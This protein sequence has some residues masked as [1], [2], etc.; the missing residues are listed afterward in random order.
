MSFKHYLLASV[1]AFLPISEL[2]AQTTTPLAGDASNA[3]VTATGGTTART[4]ADQAADIVNAKNYGVKG[5]LQTLSSNF[6]ISASSTALSASSGV[7]SASMVGKSIVLGGAGAAGAALITTIASYTD[8]THVTLTAA[9]STALS[10]ASLTVAVGTDDA[11]ALNAAFAAAVAKTQ[12]YSTSTNI[13]AVFVV[14]QGSYLTLESLNWT[15][16]K[17]NGLTVQM[18]SALIY[19]ATN[20]K[21]IIDALGTRWF[22]W[23]GGILR[24]DPYAPPNVGL[25]IGRINTTSQDSS[26]N[27]HITDLAI[28]GYFSLAGFYDM[29]VEQSLFTRLHVFNS[30]QGAYSAIFDGI[31]HFG[32]T[33]QFVTVSQPADTPQSFLGNQFDDCI[34]YGNN[35]SGGAIWLAGTMGMLFHTGYVV[36]TYAGGGAL[37]GATLYNI[38]SSINS[39]L[40]ADIHFEGSITSDWFI[41]GTNTT[42]VFNGFQYF[43][44]HSM[45]SQYVIAWDT[46]ITFVTLTNS[47]YEVSL[48]P[49]GTVIFQDPTKMTVSGRWWTASTSSWPSSPQSFQGV[50]QLGAGYRLGQLSAGSGTTVTGQGA[51]AAGQ[52]NLASGLA[53]TA[54]GN[55]NQTAGAYSFAAGSAVSDAADSAF[56]YGSGAFSSTDAQHRMAVMRANMTTANTTYQLTTNGSQTITGHSS[57]GYGSLGAGS[58]LVSCKM[59]AHNTSTQDGASWTLD[60]ALLTRGSTAATLTVVGGGTWTQTQASAGATGVFTPTFAADTAKDSFKI[61]LTASSGAWHAI[62]TCTEEDVR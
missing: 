23:S 12:T 42:P 19:G 48:V 62:A 56:V 1:I 15:N 47:V 51:S 57:L 2:A 44:D 45:A 53:S 35:P 59:V 14:P 41:A 37:Y 6:T 55:A 20:G 32:L 5:D 29:N 11:P 31:N 7:F 9:A 39:T 52:F 8:S 38:P 25:Q 17:N 33:S 18:G 40:R 43:N 10:A 61:T 21:P 27:H 60:N 50:L 58:Y 54:F 28:G 22:R 13:Q 24:G 4:L 26:D 34:F 30:Y 36:N 16:V 3:R 49:S 46:N